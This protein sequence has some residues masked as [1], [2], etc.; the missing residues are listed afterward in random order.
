MFTAKVYNV[1][2]GSL[3]GIMEEEYA[4][5]DLIRRCNQQRAQAT[6]RVLLPA[7]WTTDPAA[8]AP[9]D[10][11]IALVDNWVGDT[12][13]VDHCLAA[14][15]RVIL[16]FNAFADPGNTIESEHQAVAAFRQRVQS[17]CKCLEYRGT[18]ELKQRVEEAIG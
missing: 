15:K 2:V 10:V 9:V 14:G 7:E 8:L 3:S 1:M 6:G 11:V 4:V 12:S 17:R 13:A 18:A 5:K 16:L